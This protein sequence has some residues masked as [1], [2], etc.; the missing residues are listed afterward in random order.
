MNVV[1]CKL[2]NSLFDEINNVKQK[3][4]MEMK[5]FYYVDETMDD[6]SV[7][8]IA[9]ND[10]LMLLKSEYLDTIKVIVL[11]GGV[12]TS[13]LGPCSSVMIPLRKSVSEYEIFCIKETRRIVILHKDISQDF[14]KIILSE[15]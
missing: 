7:E 6:L 1:F 15:V 3:R 14:M 13:I 9:L 10:K 2:K 8:V 5:N 11:E 4:V 12:R